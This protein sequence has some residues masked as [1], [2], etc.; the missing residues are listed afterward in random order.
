LARAFGRHFAQVVIP[1]T[2][3]RHLGTVVNN[4][5]LIGDAL[6]ERLGLPNAAQRRERQHLAL[7]HALRADRVLL[8]RRLHEDKEPLAQ[9]PA[10][11]WLLLARQRSGQ[12][13][14]PS[15]AWLPPQ[16]TRP[17]TPVPR[18]QPTAQGRLPALVSA[19]QLEALRQCPYRFFARAVLRL[20]E[21]QELDAALAKRDYGNWLHHLLHHFHSQRVFG[22][23]DFAQLEAAAQAATA[24]LGLDDGEL[25]PF[26]ASFE[27]L[28]PAYLAWLHQRESQGWYWA[29]G[30]SDHHRAD[31]QLGSTQLR[32]R[33]DRLDHGPDD[34]RQLIDYKTSRA[35]DL[36][37]RV[38][39]P[40]EDTQLA[41]YAALLGG[42]APLGALYLALD[43]DDA[44]RE[45][46]HPAVQ[47]TAAT[48][49]AAVG[50]EWQRMQ[51][52]A[53]L[54]ALGEGKVCEGCEA[55]GLC[56][57]DQWA[58]P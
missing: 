54:P 16:T 37:S 57:R 31:T 7:A 3:Q 43:E 49:V 32:G 50:G 27:R 33:I 48:L 20:D 56:R 2:D 38:K 10:V 53:A 39:Q 51:Q 28:A 40:L 1:A 23:D 35:A 44:P 47:D 14:W 24:A 30:E 8:L 9:S 36:R 11:R 21:P 19:S 52:G 13:A 6:A 42:D 55:R 22:G 15:T 46:P 41:F 4:S 18:P 29:D 34:A 26:A 25:L 58:A 12:A 17:A 5:G 45:V